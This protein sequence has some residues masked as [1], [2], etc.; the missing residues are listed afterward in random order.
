MPKQGNVSELDIKI[1]LLLS[2]EVGTKIKQLLE[3]IELL[4]T[5]LAELK[6]SI[7]E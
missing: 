1:S 2:D 4:E 5:E 6:A 3:T 7:K